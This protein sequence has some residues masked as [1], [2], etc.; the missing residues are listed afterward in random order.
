MKIKFYLTIL[1]GLFSSC[2]TTSY[3]YR[4]SVIGLIRDDKTPL[5]NV[6]IVYDSLDVLSPRNVITNNKGQFILPKIEMKNYQNF[7]KSIKEINSMIIIKKKGYDTKKINLKTYDMN[8]D[9]IDIGTIYLKS[10]Q[11]NSVNLW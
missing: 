4:K 5:P 10:K 8:K 11:S 2:N 6:S 1:L 3:I 9:T 7:I